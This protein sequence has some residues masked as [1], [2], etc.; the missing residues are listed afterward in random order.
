MMNP[1]RIRYLA[2]LAFLSL[3]IAIPFHI[4]VSLKWT[5]LGPVGH[6]YFGPVREMHAVNSR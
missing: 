2:K 1:F 4:E 3:W 6:E 5:P